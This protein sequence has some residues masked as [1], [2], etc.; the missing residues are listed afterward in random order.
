MAERILPVA[1]DETIVFIVFGLSE[2]LRQKCSCPVSAL[3]CAVRGA[4][5]KKAGV[6]CCGSIVPDKRSTQVPEIP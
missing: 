3:C 2:L 5:R 6:L 4:G 1:D